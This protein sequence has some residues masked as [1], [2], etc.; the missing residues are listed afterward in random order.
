MRNK[1]AQLWFAFW[2][3]GG[4]CCPMNAAANPDAPKLPDFGPVLQ[5][6]DPAL[7]LISQAMGLE[8]APTEKISDL[9]P[10]TKEEA[11]A[12]ECSINEVCG[13]AEE[14]QH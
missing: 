8:S 3:Q 14:S 10:W 13:Q 7:R 12:F 2:V 5:P 1:L 11:D 4:Y 9:P 6:A